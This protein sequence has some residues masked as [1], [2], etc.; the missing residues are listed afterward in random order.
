METNGDDCQA[1][2]STGTVT[3]PIVPQKCIDHVILEADRKHGILYENLGFDCL[4]FD[5]T[6]REPDVE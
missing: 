4:A 6:T 1:F 2:S 5:C 3:N